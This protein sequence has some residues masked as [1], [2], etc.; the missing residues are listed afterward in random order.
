MMFDSYTTG[1][2]V[3]FFSIVLHRTYV[4]LVIAFILIKYSAALGLRIDGA[5][6]QRPR[7]VL[8]TFSPS[9]FASL[10]PSTPS[11][12]NRQPMSPAL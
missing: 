4:A 11:S 1:L 7:L 2:K 10:Y 5:P 6:L 9:F 3:D 12:A 8:S